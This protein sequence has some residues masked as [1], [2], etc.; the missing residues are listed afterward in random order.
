MQTSC[1]TTVEHNSGTRTRGARHTRPRRAEDTINLDTGRIK[2][3]IYSPDTEQ[4]GP[5]LSRCCPVCRCRT[6]WVGSSVMAASR[7]IFSLDTP[8][9]GPADLELV[10]R[11]PCLCARLR[12]ATIRRFLNRYQKNPEVMER[13][14]L[15]NEIDLFSS[16]EI[17]L[18]ISLDS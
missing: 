11:D 10:A 2:S 3:R 15:P 5:V 9:R 14:T 8:A 18:R 12:S 7:S 16:I 6:V 1:R 17:F 4:D 13:K